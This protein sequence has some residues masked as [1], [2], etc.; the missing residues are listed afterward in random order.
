MTKGLWTTV[1]VVC[2]LAAWA[3]PAVTVSVEPSDPAILRE[4]PTGVECLIYLSVNNDSNATLDSLILVADCGG[5]SVVRSLLPVKPGKNTDTL[6]LPEPV[7]ARID[8]SVKRGDKI[9]WQ[10]TLER[11][12]N[13][14]ARMTVPLSPTVKIEQLKPKM[15]R[16]TNY[17]PR[18][19]PWAGIWRHADTPVLDAE[20]SVMNELNVN[21]FRTFYF[22]DE[23]S[24]LVRRD[25]TV[26]PAKLKRIDHLLS[27]AGRHRLKV[28]F[29]LTGSQPYTEELDTWRRF[30]RTGIEPF[31]YDG[32]V[33]MWDL[34]NEPG[35]VEG[36]KASPPLSRWIQTMYPELEKLAPNHMLTVGLCWQFDQLWDLGVKPPVGQYHNYSSA[37]GVQPEGRPPVRNVADDLAEIKRFIGDRP[38]VIG[39][40]GYP[41]QATDERKDASEERQRAIYE[42]ILTGVDATPIAGVFNWTL[43]HFEPDWMGR[44]EQSFGVVRLDGTLKPA[45]EL[46]KS[47]YARWKNEITAP[48]E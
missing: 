1:F 2:S 39:E 27:V 20:F 7:P 45:G 44:S 6:W 9:V 48:W 10:G 38:L 26:T 42:G 13:A 30:F 18:R 22:F 36:P 14:S 34:I 31:A 47:A 43:F 3:A 15:L 25:G 28:L 19:T 33:L 29:C 21:T 11:P 12:A 35:G 37:I 4:T 8:T 23:E 32:R 46:L 17:L 41:S 5:T 40:F 24:G 16:G